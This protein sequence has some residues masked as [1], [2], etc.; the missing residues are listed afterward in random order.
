MVETADGEI[1]VFILVVVLA[2]T[3]DN[4]GHDSASCGRGELQAGHDG[5]FDLESIF[6]EEEFGECGVLAE[7][8]H[9][10][11]PAWGWVGEDVEEVGW[12]AFRPD[13]Y[14]AAEFLEPDL[15]PVL[16]H[17]A[18]EEFELAQDPEPFVEVEFDVL[19]DG[20]TEE[21]SAPASAF[22]VCDWAAY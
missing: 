20:G 4:R 21:P 17:W 7:M 14:G 10:G 19:F 16:A 15:A 22:A 1:R 9:A 8:E 11:E 2:T 6:D 3:G 12:D 13:R 18:G 5:G